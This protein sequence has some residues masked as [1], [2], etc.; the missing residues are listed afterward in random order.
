MYYR[1][2]SSLLHEFGPAQ[3]NSTALICYWVNVSWDFKD[4]VD[5]VSSRT[6]QNF[7]NGMITWFALGEDQK[8]NFTNKDTFSAQYRNF[9]EFFRC[10]IYNHKSRWPYVNCMQSWVRAAYLPHSGRRQ[11]GSSFPRF[12]EP[13]SEQYSER[14]AIAWSRKRPRSA[15]TVCKSRYLRF[16]Q[17]CSFLNWVPIEANNC[18]GPISS[19]SPCHAI[20]IRLDSDA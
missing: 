19:H 2:P 4:V 14:T 8:R 13:A 15:V 20:S 9:M 12:H 5:D 10:F 7:V 1:R 18:L 11:V 17:A 16:R 3:R 6:K